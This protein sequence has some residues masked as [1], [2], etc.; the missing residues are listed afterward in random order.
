MSDV[1]KVI[2]MAKANNV[3]IVDLRFCDMP[4]VWQHTSVPAYRLDEDAFENG[5]G[6]DGSSIPSPRTRRSSSSA[7]SS[8]RSPASPTRATPATSPRRP[9]PT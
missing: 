5:F 4:G 3:Q 7:T 8:T 6:F 2:E 1:K 9:R